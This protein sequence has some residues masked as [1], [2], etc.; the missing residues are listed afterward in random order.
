MVRSLHGAWA[1]VLALAMLWLP[2]C[3]SPPHFRPALDD[4]PIEAGDVLLVT[5]SAN[6]EPFAVKW[7]VDKV[8]NVRLPYSRPWWVAGKRPSDLAKELSQYFS[9]R[10]SVTFK[11]EK[12]GAAFFKPSSGAS[13]SPDVAPQRPRQQPA[14]ASAAEKGVGQP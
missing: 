10:R 8:G 11:I 12:I 1:G 6:A 5:C 3:A 14:T 7:T 4:D 9:V 13:S 2:G